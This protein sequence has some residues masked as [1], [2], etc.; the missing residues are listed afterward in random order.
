MAKMY[1]TFGPKTNESH[2]AEPKFYNLLKN[3][4]DDTYTVIH[5]V[6]WLSSAIKE[7]YGDIS[8]IGEVDFLVIHPIR[9]VLAVEVGG[10]LQRC[11]WLL[12]QP[13]WK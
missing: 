8:A 6:P 3:G 7:I 10:I 9:G 2:Y 1:P 13:G 4:L 11:K 12:L 5:S